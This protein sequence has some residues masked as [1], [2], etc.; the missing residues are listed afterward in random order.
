[1]ARLTRRNINECRRWLDAHF[2]T[3]CTDRE[4]VKSDSRQWFCVR[5]ARAN[6]LAV[7]MNT[8]RDLVR[9]LNDHGVC[10]R[11]GHHD[12][13]PEVEVECI[14]ASHHIHNARHDDKD[15]ASDTTSVQVTKSLGMRADCLWIAA[16]ELSKNLQNI[17]HLLK[18]RSEI[19]L[20]EGVDDYG[21]ERW[22]VIDNRELYASEID[23]LPP[24]RPDTRILSGGDSGATIVPF[25]KPN[26]KVRG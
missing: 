2:G 8:Q 24:T 4:L 15:Q 26:P 11:L 3:P 22:H 16:E 6:P 25:P 1:M 17:E 12:Q 18:T 5:L 19:S 14:T 20:I 13:S 23:A 21:N 9:L 10:A 7:E